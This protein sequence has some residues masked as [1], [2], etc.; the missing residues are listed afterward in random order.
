MDDQI[1]GPELWGK[2]P[3]LKSVFACNNLFA[4]DIFAISM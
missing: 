3:V 2:A 4:V 1:L